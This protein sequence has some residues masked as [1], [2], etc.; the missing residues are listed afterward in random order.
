LTHRVNGMAKGIRE[1]AAQPM[2]QPLRGA[3]L[4]RVI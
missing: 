3:E 2:R 1:Q 4:K